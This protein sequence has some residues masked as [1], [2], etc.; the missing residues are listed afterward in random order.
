MVA[1]MGGIEEASREGSSSL[2]EVV[3]RVNIS[4]Q[5]PT[6]GR[7]CRM[8]QT[9]ATPPNASHW[10]PQS[11]S[12]AIFCLLLEGFARAFTRSGV[13]GL[14]LAGFY[15]LMNDIVAATLRWAAGDH[16]FCWL[17]RISGPH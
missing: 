16:S 4:A 3:R 15:R 14:W 8:S 6:H 12:G 5:T 2:M 7:P 17:V 11:L 13:A 9:W 1:P 10:W